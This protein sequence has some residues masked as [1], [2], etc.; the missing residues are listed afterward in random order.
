M[1]LYLGLDSSTQSLSAIVIE[2]DA[3]V[4]RVV[5]E[6][7]LAFDR[8]FP[9]YGTHHGVLP[10][11]EPSVAVSSPVLWAA[12]L[13]AMMARL[14]AAVDVA[15][16]AAISGSAQQH[17]SVYLNATAT[18]ALGSLDPARSLAEQV[19]PM[20]SRPVS[21][22]WMDSSTSAECRAIAAAVGGDATLAR[23]TGSRAFERFTGPQIRKFAT[24]EPEAYERTD[25]VHLVSSFLAS[26]LAG[27]HAPIDPGDGSGMNLMDLESATW[28]DAATT[29]TAPGLR[30]K[31]P[32][33]APA[34]SI[35]G[36]LAP[37]WQVKHG[38]PAAAQAGESGQWKLPR[39]RTR[40][41][42]TEW[43]SAR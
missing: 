33:L 15:R 26:L 27:R 32:T 8:D 18:A 17:G 21:P 6:D 7:S 40:R 20:L 34:S 13:E 19:G 30:A 22:I 42:R 31:L 16:I 38:F 3:G 28:W 37:Y 36:P 23:H 1:P 29:A 12:A 5:F 24:H 14:A 35:V 10:S 4:R 39:P 2:V 11:P 25:R 41:S 9:E 43:S